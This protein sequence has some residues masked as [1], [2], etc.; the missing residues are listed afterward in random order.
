MSIGNGLGAYMKSDPNNFIE[1]WHEYMRIQIALDTSR[2]LKSSLMLSNKGEK[3]EDGFL[4]NSQ[5]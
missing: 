5:I 1:G 4:S 3:K 2:V